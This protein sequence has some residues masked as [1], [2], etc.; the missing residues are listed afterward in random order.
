MT[1]PHRGRAVPRLDSVDR[2]LAN[3]IKV[4]VSRWNELGCEGLTGIR[5][6]PRYPEDTTGPFAA[7]VYWRPRRFS[8][9]CIIAG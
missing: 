1:P 7:G 4:A 9:S 5:P 6:C 2:N 3:V 8:V